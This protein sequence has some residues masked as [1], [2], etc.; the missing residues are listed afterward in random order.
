MNVMIQI[1]PLLS[2]RNALQ[3]RLSPIEL[4]CN[5]WRLILNPEKCEVIMFGYN[6]GRP[7]SILISLNNITLKQVNS[8]KCL[9]VTSSSRLGWKQHIDNFS[10]KMQAQKWPTTRNGK[11]KEIPN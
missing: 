2:T 5:K 9:G 4:W 6:G 11:T 3:R 7:P 10:K 8:L 1:L